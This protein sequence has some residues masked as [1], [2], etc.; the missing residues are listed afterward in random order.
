MSARGLA[1]ALAVFFNESSPAVA[2]EPTSEWRI[3]P[4]DARCVAVRNFGSADGPVTLAIKAPPTGSSLQVA[5]I[6]SG[7]VRSPEQLGATIRVGDQSFDTFALRYPTGKKQSVSLVN[8]LEDAVAATRSAAAL[9]VTVAGGFDGRFSLAEAGP[10]WSQLDACLGRLRR[11]WNVDDEL[12][13]GTASGARAIL[14]IQSLFSADD[15]PAL[16]VSEE[17]QG[18]TGFLL[19]IDEKGAVQDCTLTQSSGVA[20]LDSRS[21]GIV[22]A[23]GKFAPAMG[24]DGQPIKSYWSQRIT[25][26][27]VG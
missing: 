17:W 13:G 10:M 15:Y 21:C 25:W 4:S 11:T 7:H 16:A 23:R 8:L 5:I 12:Q 19:L 14:P 3:E 22:R 20:I 2:L 9:E 18:T 1:I 27:L 6:R 26:R 24:T